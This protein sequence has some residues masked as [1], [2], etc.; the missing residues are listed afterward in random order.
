MSE[1]DLF[2]ELLEYNN[3]VYNEPEYENC[4]HLDVKEEGGA[5][6][7]IDCGE[8]IKRELN[9]D[10]EWRYYGADDTRRNSDPNRCQIRKIE[11]K[12]IFKDV[13]N[14]GFCDKIVHSAND[15]YTQITNGKIYRGNSRKSIVFACI[16]HA[17]KLSNKPQS[18]EYLQNIF[19]LEKKIVLK[20]LKFVSLNVPKDSQ[21]R[22]KYITAIQ[23]I[24][25]I[26]VDIKVTDQDRQE[27]IKIYEYVKNRSS[28]LNRSR[29]QSFASG[30]IYY[31]IINYNK[32]FNLKE[33]IKKIKLSEL[34]ISKISKEIT[35]IYNESTVL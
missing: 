30:L 5:I 26:L 25:E 14:M 20:G 21:I 1:F 17:Y 15:I 19:K 23:L 10:K 22:T 4:E 11:D 27:V 31:W 12:S 3:E 7:C 28:I 16:F 32:N 6:L 8:E 9:F 13:E 35:R 33:F 24:E 18:C 29:P 2:R 34:T